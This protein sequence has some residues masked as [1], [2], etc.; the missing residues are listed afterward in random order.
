MY[1]SIRLTPK[2]PA[3]T[4]VTRTIAALASIISHVATMA[5][6]RMNAMRAGIRATPVHFMMFLLLMRICFLVK[7][8]RHDK[9]RATYASPMRK[10]AMMPVV[11]IASSGC[12]ASAV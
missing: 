10:L 2:T 4:T 11:S 9:G 6:A 12:D 5:S 1:W 8:S 3:D 7:H